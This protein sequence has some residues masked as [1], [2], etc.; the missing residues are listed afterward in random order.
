MSFF[1]YL[2][3]LVTNYSLDLEDIRARESRILSITTEKRRETQRAALDIE[4]LR[5]YIFGNSDKYPWHSLYDTKESSDYLLREC[6]REESR[7]FREK[8]STFRFYLRSS[9]AIAPYTACFDYF[10]P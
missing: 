4:G 7:G 9:K 5:D 10:L 1:Y 6:N 2:I 8:L 3:E